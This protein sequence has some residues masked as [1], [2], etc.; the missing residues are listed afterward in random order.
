ML[1]GNE[2]ESERETQWRKHSRFRPLAWEPSLQGFSRE[3]EILVIYQL[4]QSRAQPD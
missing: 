3:T 2:M 1:M 4:S